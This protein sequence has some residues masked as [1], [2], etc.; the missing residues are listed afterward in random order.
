MRRHPIGLSHRF[1]KRIRDRRGGLGRYVPMA[2]GREKPLVREAPGP[3][4][5]RRGR[6]KARVF[7]PLRRVADGF[8]EIRKNCHMRKKLTK[9]KTTGI[10]AGD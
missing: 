9:V 8:R 4:A 7:R 3:F 6:A 5:C 1:C 10:V 2:A